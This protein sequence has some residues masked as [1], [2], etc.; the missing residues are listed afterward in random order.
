MV[1]SKYRRMEKERVISFS[2]RERKFSYRPIG[3]TFVNT[4]NKHGSTE[5]L[6]IS[7]D[8]DAFAAIGG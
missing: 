1:D 6:E 8:H 7:A 2:Q 4:A 5:D 3:R